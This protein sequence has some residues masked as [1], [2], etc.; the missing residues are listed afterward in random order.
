MKKSDTNKSPGDREELFNGDSMVKVLMEALAEGAVIINSEGQIVYINKRAEELFGY[1]GE[2]LMGQSLNILLPGRCAEM[3][4]KHVSRYLL[5]PR[6][7]P[8]G[9]QL[10]LTG[11][12]KDGS[13]FPVAVSLAFLKKNANTYGLALVTDISSLKKLERE[14]TN[15]NEELD[16]FAHTVAHDLKSPLQVLNNYC[17]LLLFDRED[18]NAEELDLTLGEIIKSVDRMSNIVNEL[19]IFSRI[20]M[21]EI[22]TVPLY[23]EKIIGQ[24][25]KRLDHEIKDVHAHIILSERY[26]LAMGYGPLIEEV[27]VN[28]ISNALKYGGN[29]PRIEI[30]SS[31][32]K[33]GYVKFW[34]KDNGKGI[35]KEQQSCIFLEGTRLDHPQIK[36][37]GLG[38]SI[39]KRIIEKLGGQVALESTP[40]KGSVFSF[41]L[42]AK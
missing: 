1:G 26:P 3:H 42:P 12:R 34:L 6:V 7:R 25:L 4:A 2:A 14:L 18:L 31:L 36:G 39:V 22:K 21:E 27:W 29:P 20:K 5:N 23:M 11:K 15:R 41:T 10:S 38:L 24:V 37:H 33:N 17:E 30:G 32:E 40:G 8:M 28:Y 13:E 16:A 35:N 9:E 19:L